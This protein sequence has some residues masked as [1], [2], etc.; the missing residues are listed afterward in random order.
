MKTRIITAIVAVAV[1]LPFVIFSD[2]F[3]WLIAIGVI[4][5]VSCYE[6]LRCLSLHKCLPIAIPSYIAML[7]VVLLTRLTSCI[8]NFYICSFAIYFAYI[9]YVITAAMFSKGKIKI[10][11]AALMC[12]MM[13]YITFGYSSLILLRDMNNGFHLMLLAIIVPWLYDGGA[14]FSGYLL[15][16]HKLIPDISPKKTVEGTVGGVIIGTLAMTAYP[17]IFVPDAVKNI[18]AFIIVGIIVCAISQCGDLIMSYIKRHYGIK[19]YG[20]ILPGHGGFLDRFDS[21]LPTAA[22]MVI[23]FSLSEFFVLLK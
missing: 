2:T 6:L 4:A 17:F 23:L 19:D 20:N 10:T 18:P 12:C 8:E 21:I 11:E 5:E 15:G 22:A 3:A 13:I 16:K 1:F 9:F 14:Y 7:G